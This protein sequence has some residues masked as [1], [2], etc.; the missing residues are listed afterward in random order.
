MTLISNRKSLSCS[1][2]EGLRTLLVESITSRLCRSRVAKPASQEN[3]EPTQTTWFVHSRA[4][5]IHLYLVCSYPHFVLTCLHLFLG[6]P[7]RLLTPLHEEPA[8]WDDIV[9][10]DIVRLD[11]VVV[12]GNSL[13]KIKL[14][15]FQVCSFNG[16]RS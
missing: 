14:E 4:L 15:D 7:F 11:S 13:L 9:N 8:Y 16:I 2:I 1:L 3:G 6:G 10:G 12:P 5:I